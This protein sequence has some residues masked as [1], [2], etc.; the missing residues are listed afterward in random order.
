M[1][2]DCLF[3]I[4]QQP[5]DKMTVKITGTILNVL[6]IILE[7]ILMLE[8]ENILKIPCPKICND[9]INIEMINETFHIK[10]FLLWG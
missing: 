7:K 10:I 1:G 4:L 8:V 9:V 5:S 6:V 2:P 3:L